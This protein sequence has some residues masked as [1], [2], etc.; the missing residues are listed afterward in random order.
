M[1]SYPT[2]HTNTP[3]S[4]RLVTLQASCNLFSTPL[5]AAHLASPILSGPLTSLIT[6]SLLDR[7]HTPCRVAATSLVFNLAVYTQKQRSVYNEEVFNGLSV[8]L[9]ASVVEA[10]KSEVESKDVVKGL[11]LS[12]ALLCY[13]APLD[14]EVG[15]VA[16]VLEAG[17]MVR[18]QATKGLGE[19]G[20]CEEVARLLES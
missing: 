10:L 4:L 14:E 9:I 13:C 18:E 6:S 20:L 12:L 2:T 17:A 1:I 15:E 3:Y 19:K 11:I 16:K 8:D 5:F 7:T